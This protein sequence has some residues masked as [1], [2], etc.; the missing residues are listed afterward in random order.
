[1]PNKLNKYYYNQKA[2]SFFLK[3]I[4]KEIFFK[5]VKLSVCESSYNKSIRSLHSFIVT[6]KYNSINK[7][8]NKGVLKLILFTCSNI[9]VS[10]KSS[11]IRPI[12]DNP[13]DIKLYEK[14]IIKKKLQKIINSDFI[15]K[16]KYIKEKTSIL[17]KVVKRKK[18]NIV[19]NTSF[20]IFLFFI[21]SKRPYL[22]KSIIKYI[23][24]K[25]LFYRNKKPL[26]LLTNINN[27]DKKYVKKNN[28]LKLLV[29]LLDIFKK[30]CTFV[31]NFNRLYKVS[32]F[33]KI[34]KSNL[35]YKKAFTLK[36][37]EKPY[38]NAFKNLNRYN[39]SNKEGSIDIIDNYGFKFL[40]KNVLLI[41]LKKRLSEIE[42]KPYFFKKKGKEKNVKKIIK[43]K[44]KQYKKLRL[45]PRK[46]KEVSIFAYEPSPDETIVSPEFVND[47]LKNMAKKG[48]YERK[49][50]LYAYYEKK[51]N[52]K[53]IDREKKKQLKNES[54]KN[55]IYNDFFFKNEK[56]TYINKQRNF[57]NEWNKFYKYNY[58]L[59]LKSLVKNLHYLN[60]K[61]LQE[62]NTYCKK[63]NSIYFSM[64]KELNYMLK[65]PYRKINNLELITFSKENLK[66]EENFSSGDNYNLYD[67]HS[68]HKIKNINKKWISL[69]DY[70][71]LKN[72][73]KV[74]LYNLLS[75][76]IVSDEFNEKLE[77]YHKFKLLKSFVKDNKEI[78]HTDIEINFKFF[79]DKMWNF[80]HNT[81]FLGIESSNLS[82][83]SQIKLKIRIL[84]KIVAELSYLKK[85][86]LMPTNKKETNVKVDKIKT[87]S[88]MYTGYPTE[89][90]KYK[91][92][93]SFFSNKL[94]K[95]V[96]ELNKCKN[97]NNNKI[98]EFLLE[99]NNLFKLIAKNKFFNV[100]YI[101]INMKVVDLINVF[102]SNLSFNKSEKLLMNARD[103]LIRNIKW[104]IEKEISSINE[105]YKNTS[106]N[107][108]IY[109][110][111]NSIKKISDIN[112]LFNY[113]DNNWYNVDKDRILRK[114]KH[115][116]FLISELLKITKYLPLRILRNKKVSINYILTKQVE[117]LLLIG[118]KDSFIC[119]NSL[120]ITNFRKEV[121]NNLLKVNINSIEE[122]NKLINNIKNIIELKKKVIKY[123]GIKTI[124]NKLV[125][126]RL[127]IFLLDKN[128]VEIN[129][130][131]YKKQGLLNIFDFSLD[132]C[133]NITR[134]KKNLCILLID[135]LLH[136]NKDRLLYN[137]FF[138]KIGLP[139]DTRLLEVEKNI[140]KKEKKKIFLLYK[141][142]SRSLINK[143]INRTGSWFNILNF[144][145]KN[146]NK[147]YIKI[148]RVRKKKIVSTMKNILN[149]KYNEIQ[150]K[151]KNKSILLIRRHNTILKFLNYIFRYNNNSNHIKK[152]LLLSLKSFRKNILNLSLKNLIYTLKERIN[153]YNLIKKKRIKFV[154]KQ[155][156]KLNL[157]IL[158]GAKKWVRKSRYISAL[159]LITKNNLSSN[160]LTKQCSNN[161]T[162]FN[163]HY[164][165]INLPIDKIS[166]LTK[167]KLY[168][169]IP[170]FNKEF[171][172]QLEYTINEYKKKIKKLKDNYFKLKN[173]VV[174]TRRKLI[175]SIKIKKLKKVLYNLKSKKIKKLKG[176]NNLYFFNIKDKHKNTIS[177]FNK[178]YLDI[179]S[180]LTT[181]ELNSNEKS[182]LF[183]KN[184]LENKKDL[185]NVEF[186][187]NRKKEL[188]SYTY[189]YESG[190]FSNY[191][192]RQ[193]LLV[194]AKN[195]STHIRFNI[196]SKVKDYYKRSI[197]DKNPIKLDK[198]IYQIY[199][200]WELHL[201]NYNYSLI[202][203]KTKYMNIKLNKSVKSYFLIRLS[204]EFRWIER[205]LEN[206]DITKQKIMLSWVLFLVTKDAKYIVDII[207]DFVERISYKK[208]KYVL[209]KI[210]RLV[211]FF[212]KYLY[213]QFLVKAVCFELKGK[214]G[215]K[216]SVRKKKLKYRSGL[217]TSNSNKNLK[218][219]RSSFLIN[220]PTGVMGGVLKL[221]F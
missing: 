143:R 117:A 33:K 197:L 107:Y 78:K 142:A 106:A 97:N 57:K 125:S 29:Y 70:L 43:I 72:I 150:K 52:L 154:K 80:F 206:S 102:N 75:K 161:I 28:M 91:E 122:F 130:K 209:V 64:K 53:K 139:K 153:K 74:N 17:E 58:K 111:K 55:R 217:G 95:Y 68:N 25:T 187:D 23:Y 136:K 44:E 149:N 85:M 159:K 4:Q 51:K 63:K 110:K 79:E 194:L 9:K 82:V 1:M 205:F 164:E 35:N 90:L 45:V 101:F 177:K 129:N 126:V 135:L 112:I 69:I 77:I 100:N 195:N 211:W 157:S 214:I 210:K 113:N 32:G 21:I 141:L 133:Y 24:I 108:C 215:V 198:K 168:N 37:E 166:F 47:F 160:L 5:N 131:E 94:S 10:K 183:K 189:N 84:K 138:K 54:I 114:K 191:N 165:L 6:K 196:M 8:F 11:I 207:V 73:K 120:R 216:G 147:K 61:R 127:N 87:I 172:I 49:K 62:T 124:L 65:N 104:L 20:I 115:V 137:K 50:V 22:N 89:S 27:F 182:I 204:N 16:K 148:I 34:K 144:K 76:G 152:T 56:G 105:L 41:R 134:L 163:D 98:K 181:L 221:T 93:S 36:K 123:K 155:N 30:N 167:Y 48:K 184:Y 67:L 200:I 109:L 174:Y 71:E 132:K 213:G 66:L 26:L 176:I 12:I 171:I 190:S 60:C 185:S 40:V 158:E 14:N 13:S 173:F 38:I 162:L 128:V 219:T 7:E 146:W 59:N 96:K 208:H 88:K 201:I 140:L 193:L 103:S 202:A 83:E 151:K 203:L 199:K 15:E 175:Y 2:S 145:K 212:S 42:Y 81:F 118:K 39:A 186:I 19:N 178:F 156:N 188:I 46:A 170:I 192:L 116:L 3:L 121:E 169:L 86:E 18:P 179:V 99:R 92:L 220:T 31:L 119:L 180:E 218:L